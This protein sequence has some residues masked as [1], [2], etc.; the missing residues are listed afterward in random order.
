M[1]KWVQLSDF[2]EVEEIC[3]NAIDAVVAAISKG[4]VMKVRWNACYAAGK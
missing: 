4:K 3:S 2:K 1:T